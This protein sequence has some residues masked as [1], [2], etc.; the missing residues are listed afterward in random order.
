MHRCACISDIDL[1]RYRA[2][3]PLL[4]SNPVGEHLFWLD[5][6]FRDVMQSINVPRLDISCSR[7]RT[8]HP[9]P[10]PPQR[11][12]RLTRAYSGLLRSS[13]TSVVV[14]PALRP[15]R[16]ETTPQLPPSDDDLFGLTPSFTTPTRSEAP[17]ELIPTEPS[18]PDFSFFGTKAHDRTLHREKSVRLVDVQAVLHYNR[19]ENDLQP[20]HW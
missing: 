4:H 11:P 16:R 8:H 19:G 10:M 5:F 3:T 20:W 9:A 7:S 18:T 15:E 1:C 12:Q 14:E 17:N 6:G 13:R 2:H